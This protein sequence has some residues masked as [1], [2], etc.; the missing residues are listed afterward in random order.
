MEEPYMWR[1]R[2]RGAYIVHKPFSKALMSSLRQSIAQ[3]YILP[4]WYFLLF[5]WGQYTSEHTWLACMPVSDW[6]LRNRTPIPVHTQ[7]KTE[8]YSWS[9]ANLGCC[10]LGAMEIEDKRT[11]NCCA[12]CHLVLLRCFG[13]CLKTTLLLYFII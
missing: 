7:E 13:I 10:S 8:E 2:G 5:C 1:E 4:H 11:S 12:I 3:R 6:C 9:T